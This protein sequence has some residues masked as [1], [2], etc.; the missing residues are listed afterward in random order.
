[1]GVVKKY[2]WLFT[3]G[4]VAGA[5]GIVANAFSLMYGD[6]A[7]SVNNPF[8][9]TCIEMGLLCISG[10]GAFIFSIGVLMRLATLTDNTKEVIIIGI[11]AV[12]YVLAYILSYTPYIHPLPYNQF[13]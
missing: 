1:M 12:A 13:T 2:W 5:L 9:L 11:I 3:L 6:A 7:C 10:V 8:T 4:V